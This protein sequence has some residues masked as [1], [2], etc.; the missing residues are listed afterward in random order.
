MIYDKLT[1]Y[2]SQAFSLVELFVHLLCIY[3]YWRTKVN[4]YVV[5]HFLPSHQLSP[6][7]PVHNAI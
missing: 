5:T 1:F 2:L 4:L 7:G 3:P 6:I